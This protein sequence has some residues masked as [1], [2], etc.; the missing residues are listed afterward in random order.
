MSNL[1]VDPDTHSGYSLA[2]FEHA[3]ALEVRHRAAAAGLTITA[4]TLH[5]DID[6]RTYERWFRGETTIG[7]RKYLA[8]LRI[9]RHAEKMQDLAAG[10]RADDRP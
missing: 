7:M 8:L 10:K 9:V 3:L 6:R 5:A 1:D 4:L 2:H